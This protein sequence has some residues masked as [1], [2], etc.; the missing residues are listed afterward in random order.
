VIIIVLVLHDDDSELVRRSCLIPRHVGFSARVTYPVTERRKTGRERE[1][2][3]ERNQPRCPGRD[4]L[5]YLTSTRR[6]SGLATMKRP[7]SKICDLGTFRR[8]RESVRFVR[9]GVYRF[10]IGWH[11]SIIETRACSFFYVIGISLSP[12][13]FLSDSF[14]LATD[15]PLSPRL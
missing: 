10:S 13:L 3:R 2:E 14:L 15:A 12:S 9:G 1:R 11:P 5:P 6:Q 7:T 8:V 4:N